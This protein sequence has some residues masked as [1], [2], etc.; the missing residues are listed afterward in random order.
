[1]E[2]M[3]IRA[4]RPRQ[5]RYQAALRPDMHSFYTAPARARHHSPRWAHRLTRNRAVRHIPQAPAPPC[6]PVK[7]NSKPEII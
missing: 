4:T 5:V 2:G 1:M 3:E 7:T 6:P